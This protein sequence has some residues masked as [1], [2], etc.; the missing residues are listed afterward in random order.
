MRLRV[1]IVLA[2]ATG[3][4]AAEPNWDS[5]TIDAARLLSQYVQLDTTNPPGN[6]LPAARWLERTLAEHGIAA[7]I[8]PSAENRGNLLARVP[9]SGKNQPILLLHHMDVVPAVA[10]DWSFPPFSG[11]IHDGFVYGRGSIDD[12]G[13]GVVQLMALLTLVHERQPCTRDVVFLAV[14]DEEV[15]GQLGARFMVEH[16]PDQVRAAAVWNE[17][18]ASIEGILADRLVSSAAVTEK[19]S[20]WLT[21][22]AA[23]EGGHGSAPTPDGAI[24]ILNAALSRVAAWQTPLHLIPPI[25]EMFDRI[26]GQM[27]P[28]GGFLL[29]HLDAPLIG[30]ITAG[31]ITKDRV[32]NGLVRN[33]IALT[34]L[35]AGVK[36]N[37]IPGHA[38]ADLDV[39]LLP[40]QPPEQFLAELTK[41]IDDPRV[42]IEPVGDIPDLLAPSP[43]DT[44]FFHALETALAGRLASNV[45]V[46]GMLTGGSDCKTFRRAGTPCYGYQPLVGTTDIMRRIHGLDERISLDNLRLGMQLTYDV[47]RTLCAE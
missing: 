13:H 6:E 27:F 14:A 15:G 40:D 29:S 30:A 43:S 44:A 23:G 1:V 24:N 3:R 37:V 9:G 16:Y 45:T 34:G 33:T 21:L 47:L 26:G 7:T 12:K 20:L 31:R 36:H 32:T 42:T 8:Y 38:E 18:G 41:V 10:A 11:A 5:L 39:R 46:P 35:R 28:A 4:A 22:A 17:G 2:L 19:N 25:R